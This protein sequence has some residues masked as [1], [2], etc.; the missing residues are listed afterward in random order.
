LVRK[1]L[2]LNLL[3]QTDEIPPDLRKVTSDRFLHLL[4]A[5]CY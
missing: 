5:V 4:S 1:T 3:F 2:W